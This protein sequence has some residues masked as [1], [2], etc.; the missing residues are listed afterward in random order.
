VTFADRLSPF[1]SVFVL[2]VLLTLP[3]PG[4]CAE[5]VVLASTAPGYGLGRVIPGDTVVTLPEG[6]TA[7][8]LLA[9]GQML[10]ITGPFEGALRSPGAEPKDLSGLEVGGTEQV[11]I[12]GTRMIG[13]TADLVRNPATVAVDPSRS[14][15][16]CLR[17]QDSV[18]LLRPPGADVVE[19]RDAA[20]GAAVRADW[21]AGAAE[22]SWPPELPL[23]DGTV[24][25]A[26]VR[27]GDG[28]EAAELSFRMFGTGFGHD[29]LWA[30]NLALAGC[31]GQAQALLATLRD[32]TVPLDLYMTTDR[33]RYPTYGFG[34]P[35]TLTVQ[36]NRDAFLYCSIREPDGRTIILFP[37][38]LS[39]GAR[40]A[41]DRPLTLPGDRLP[42]QLRAG[43]PPGDNEI[44][45]IAA[46]R[47]VSDAIPPE[48]S[49]ADF[50]PV[51]EN[52]AIAMRRAL[53]R[54]PGT[55]LAEGRLIVRV[56]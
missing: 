50:H 48:F 46:D 5:A 4:R 24:I 12:G 21:P 3:V 43:T 14:A 52:A 18:L 34:D 49:A 38:R 40:V 56:K 41:G 22:R 9:S 15:T 36:T 31:T 20:S 30:A 2:A 44:R 53:D 33:G 1:F 35:I 23:A 8:F 6:A 32:N 27:A 42:V 28:D 37:S 11:A 29:A 17:P 45:C 10:R 13:G 25:R 19:L 16:W 54:V 39:G 7:T 26:G 55:Q 47:D 51:P